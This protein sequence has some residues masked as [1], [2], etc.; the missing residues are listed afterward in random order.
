MALAFSRL[1]CFDNATDLVKELGREA[2][3]SER[4]LD[5]EINSFCVW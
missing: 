3:K 5:V 4:H 1:A 2:L